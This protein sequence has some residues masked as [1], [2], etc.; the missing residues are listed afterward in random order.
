M[1]ILIISDAWRPQVNG[2][3]R[4]LETTVKTLRQDGHEVDVV[5]PLE[6]RTIPCPSYPEIRLAIMPGAKVTRRIEAFQPDAIHISTEGPLG[7][8]ARRYCLRKGLPFTTAYHTRFPEYVNARFPLPLDLLYKGMRLFHDRAVHT[9]VATPSLQDDL[10]ARGFRNL[11]RWTRGVD[12]E[13]FRPGR[14][15]PL[16]IPR[17]IYLYVGRVAVE[18]NIQAFLDLDLEGSKLV[19]GDGPMLVQLRQEYPDVTFVG[20]MHGEELASYYAAAD[21]F[22][23]PSLTDTFGLVLLEALASGVP[24][25]AYPVTGPRDV[26]NGAPVG[27]LDEDLGRAARGALKIDPLACREFALGYSWRVSTQQFLANLQRVSDA[28]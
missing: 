12:I 1:R 27:V 19:V 8:A 16:N 9:M 3:V 24:V 20:A 4:T 14:R 15:R 11:V 21:V 10:E 17:P 13:L 7:W 26:I 23:F 5:S 28:S 25:A 2:V 18:K 22:V 6:F